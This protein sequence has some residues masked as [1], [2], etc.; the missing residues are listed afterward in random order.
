MKV[1]KILDDAETNKILSSAGEP[2]QQRKGGSKTLKDLGL[3]DVQNKLSN[4]K[5]LSLS[6]QQYNIIKN[7]NPMADDY[8]TGIRSATEIKTLSEALNDKEYAG[9]TEF[10]SDWT[11]A[12]AEKALKSGS[13]IVYSSHPIENGAFVTPSQIEARS[14][15]GSKKLYEKKVQI[16]N[17]AWIDAVEGVYADTT[18]YSMSNAYHAGD[19]GKSESYFQ[20]MSGSRSTGHF[21]TG[22][23][24]VGDKIKVD[25][26]N[27]RD[28][29]KAPVETVDFSNYNLF[30][31]KNYKT[32]MALHEDL[33][34]VNNL[35]GY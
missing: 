26:Y 14:Y 21:G 4:K 30:K 34:K 27:K 18:K 32:G 11:R 24:F 19:L 3:D 25:N 29:E 23:Y 8:H 15:A 22:T 20:M 9:E 13:V 6:E 17:V 35:I 33:K 12:M 31:P 28:G 7:S 2:I 5:K 1:V 16:E 10:V